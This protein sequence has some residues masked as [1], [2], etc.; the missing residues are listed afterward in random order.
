MSFEPDKIYLHDPHGYFDAESL[1]CETVTWSE[2][3]IDEND[4]E[5][6]RVKYNKVEKKKRMIGD[7]ILTELEKIG[8]I[9]IDEIEV[10]IKKLP[11]SQKVDFTIDVL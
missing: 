6:V 7:K 1:G 4:Y 5:Y 10:I 3:R 11:E 9:N 8:F 2:D